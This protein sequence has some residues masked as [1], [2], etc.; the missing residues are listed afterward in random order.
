MTSARRL[1]AV[2]ILLVATQ[3]C[4]LYPEPGI[5]KGEELFDTCSP[6]HGS[7]GEGDPEIEAPAIAGLPQWYIED[8]L[9][10]FQAGWRGRHAADLPA[11]RMRP[12]AETLNKDGDVSS[13][14]GF[15]A[16][17]T[18][19][20]P[21]STLDG[22]AGRGAERYALVC[23]SCHGDYGLG[24]EELRA[25]PLVNIDDWYL[26]AEL[27]NYRAGAR[28]AHVDDVFGIGMRSNTIALDDEAMK[29]VVAYVQTLR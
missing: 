15:V 21:P 22:N 19:V 18:P 17:L 24:R 12:M 6:C 25:P 16:S 26:F 11:L 9:N 1:L 5:E 7:L 23:A 20:Q 29:D 3:A 13:V 2:V 4:E 28:G 27:E 8:Q 14:A 10:S